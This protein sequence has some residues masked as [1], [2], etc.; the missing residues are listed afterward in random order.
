M[1]HHL[2]TLKSSAPFHR[3]LWFEVKP[4]WFVLAENRGKALSNYIENGPN[5]GR[6]LA[7]L[8]TGNYTLTDVTD[9]GEPLEVDDAPPQSGDRVRLTIEGTYHDAG[10]GE[11]NV[12]RDDGRTN[13]FTDS[14]GADIRVIARAKPAVPEDPK[15]DVERVVAAGGLERWEYDQYTDSYGNGADHW[16]WEKLWAVAQGN[17]DKLYPLV[18]TRGPVIGG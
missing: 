14:S 3:G 11:F 9:D 6:S 17:G 8:K 13:W 1:S 5:Y 7:V 15:C 2:R 10:G 4:D 12:R 16:R 18:T